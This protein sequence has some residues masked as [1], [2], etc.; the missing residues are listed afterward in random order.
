MTCIRHL[1]QPGE[2]TAEQL[3]GK[4]WNLRILLQAG[5]PVPT[6]FCITSDAYRTARNASHGAPTVDAELRQQVIAAYRELGAGSVAVRSSATAED[7]AAASFA[8]LQETVLGVEGEAELVAAVERCWRSLDSERARVYRREQRIADDAVAMAVVVQRMVP[9]EVAGVLFT[10]DPQDASGQAMLVEAAW[11]L[12]DA[13]VSGRVTPDRF[14]IDRAAGSV[15]SVQISCK[16]FRITPEGERPIEFERQ[17]AACLT[18]PQLVELAKLGRKVEA[19]HG[20]PRDIEWAWA[21]GKLWLLQS[22]PITVA[23]AHE[24]EQARQQQIAALAALA[25]P[26]GTVWARYNL[27]EVLPTPTPMTWA[28]VSRFM[29]GRGGL[30]RM[31]RSL[32]FDPDPIFDELG[33]IDLVCGRPYVNLSREAKMHF[34]GFP[35]VHDFAAIKADPRKAFYP[36]PTPDRAQ[37]NW[38]FVLRLPGFVFKMLRATVKI[39]SAKLVQAA[40]LRDSILPEFARRVRAAQQTDLQKLNNSELLEFLQTW[41]TATLDDFASES[42]KPAAIV[43]SALGELNKGLA[44]RM[45]VEEAGEAVRSLLSGVYFPSECDLAPALGKL[46]AGE[47]TLA[48][49]IENFGHRGPQEMELAKPRWREAPGQLRIVNHQQPKNM[50]VDGTAP[51]NERWQA[52]AI[53][54]NLPRS[55]NRALQRELATAHTYMV[56]RESGKHYLLLGYELIRLAICEVGRRSGLGDDVFFLTPDEL[57]RLLAGDDMSPTARERKRR[58]SV[59]LSLEAPP[60]IFSDDLEAIGRPPEIVGGDHLR[61]TPVSAGVAEG[62]ALVLTEPV[63]CDDVADGF[64]LVCPSTDPAWVPLFLRARGVVMETGGILSHGA[65]VAREFSLPAVVGI[66]NVQSLL[67]TG[68]RLRVDGNTGL[69]YLLD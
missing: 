22:R 8:G 55:E 18:P 66:G 56:L 1:D 44:P 15:I 6:A 28:I 29:S 7:G 32:G 67:R 17:V 11:G 31:F 52:I 54:A 24:R 68:Q 39:A 10:R 62:P 60:V 53:K 21:E 50:L 49:F 4:G 43:A 64:I 61:G 58:R 45:G 57:P 59:L 34:R 30:G 42:L 13:V 51:L 25:D 47:T 35:Y 3:G 38:R 63:A 41:T 36:T 65:I 40:N 37:V 5:L 26:R 9:A 14:H 2:E 23:G 16:P 33:Y 48:A 27:A 19:Y 12:G 46:A 69:V 20:E